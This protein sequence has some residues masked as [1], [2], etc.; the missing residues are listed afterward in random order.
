[1]SSGLPQDNIAATCTVC[2]VITADWR[3]FEGVSYCLDC[4]SD[5]V[6]DTTNYETT[7]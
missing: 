3:N 2:H 4:Y 7:C 1:M 6:K 5:I